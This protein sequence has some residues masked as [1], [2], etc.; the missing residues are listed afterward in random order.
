M[1]NERRAQRVMRWNY[2]EGI[3]ICG[4]N[5]LGVVVKQEKERAREREQ[6]RE[7]KE[8]RAR[9]REQGREGVK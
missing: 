8:E 1:C 9:K 2:A 5:T 7:S 3:P 4:I 6:G